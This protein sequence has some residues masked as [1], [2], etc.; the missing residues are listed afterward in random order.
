MGE[1][2]K[3]LCETF[4]TGSVVGFTSDLSDMLHFAKN[5]NNGCL[6]LLL[7]QM[8]SALFSTF[9][10]C[11]VTVCDSWICLTLVSIFVYDGEKG[12]FECSSWKR[13]TRALIRL[14]AAL[15]HQSPRELCL[16]NRW[17]LL[18]HCGR[19][20]VYFEQASLLTK[21][22]RPKNTD[23]WHSSRDRSG[24]EYWNKN[25]QGVSMKC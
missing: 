12:V 9:I 1:R 20:A 15:H 6:L 25:T 21:A 4:H 11:T 14:E 18:L 7:N 3:S 13:S 10:L 16:I 19:G 17:P 24:W 2:R 8:F 22:A 5:W 23:K